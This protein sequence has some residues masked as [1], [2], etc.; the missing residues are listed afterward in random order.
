MNRVIEWSESGITYE[1]DQR[2]SDIII[3]LLGLDSVGSKSVNTPGEK[4]TNNG[5]EVL[6]DAGDA[7]L[8]RAIVARA[9]YLAQDRSDIM[10]AVKE[11][12]RHMSVPTEEDWKRLKRLGRYLI[13]TP[14][15]VLDFGYQ[16][17]YK[18]VDI[19]TDSDWA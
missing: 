19:W 2:H 14:R 7:T 13:G 17:R 9:N 6:L 16:Q 4:S 12:T 5:E 3:N 11:L 8:Y 15:V 10:F 18:H 1:A